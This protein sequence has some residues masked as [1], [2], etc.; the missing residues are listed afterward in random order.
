M[1]IFSLLN[2]YNSMT[3][4]FKSYYL[5]SIKS[6][7]FMRK[8]FWFLVHCADLFSFS[9]IRKLKHYLIQEQ[10]IILTWL[11]YS[12]SFKEVFIFL[13]S[14]PF[15]TQT[16]LKMEALSNFRSVAGTSIGKHMEELMSLVVVYILSHLTSLLG[17][18]F[19][20]FIWVIFQVPELGQ[21]SFS[22]H[23]SDQPSQKP[24]SLFFPAQHE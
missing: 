17:L 20:R 18:K 1:V 14:Q 11:T 5:V 13:F 22:V 16:I 12:F 6:L 19:Y 8:L 15:V 7:C 23:P 2:S 3:P 4:F 21:F 9:S 24:P 10:D